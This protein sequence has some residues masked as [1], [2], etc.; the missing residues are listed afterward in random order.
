MLKTVM[1]KQAY[2]YHYIF[3][4]DLWLWLVN[5]TY[6]NHFPFKDVKMHISHG[7]NPITVWGLVHAYID[8][9]AN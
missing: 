8:L 2:K 9:T 6:V 7:T 4:V 3:F 1:S 5:R